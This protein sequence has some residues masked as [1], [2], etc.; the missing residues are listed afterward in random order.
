[1][2]F[3]HEVFIYSEKLINNADKGRHILLAA[4]GYSK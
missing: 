3:L 1:M 2:V 4:L